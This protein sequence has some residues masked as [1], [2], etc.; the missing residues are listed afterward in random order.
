MLPFKIYNFIKALAFQELLFSN[1]LSNFVLSVLGKTEIYLI[2]WFK[3]YGHLLVFSSEKCISSNRWGILP[4]R[5]SLGLPATLICRTGNKCCKR[6]HCL[7]GFRSL[8]FT[9][10]VN[11]GPL[12]NLEKILGASENIE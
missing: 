5:Y 2:F 3:T 1:I 6:R 11:K 8:V 4:W 9:S 7:C 10:R 12:D